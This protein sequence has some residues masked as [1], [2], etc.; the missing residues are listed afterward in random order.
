LANGKSVAYFS[1][2]HG[3]R[4]GDPLS[5]L[6]FC[7][8]EEVLSRAIAIA[9]SSGK[10]DPMIYCWGVH[11]PTHVLYA[12][13]ILIFCIATKKN[14]RYLLRIFHYYYEASGQV[15][16]PLKSKIFIGAMTANRTTMVSNLMGFTEGSIPF[17]YLGCP[18]FKG[19][20]KCV[21]FQAIVDKIKV[22]MATWK[23]SLLSIM[24][25]VQLIKSIIH[26]MLVYSFHVYQWQRRLLKTLDIW[27]KKFIQSGDLNTSK[28]CTVAWKHL[29]MPWEEGGLDLRSTSDIN[30]GLLLRLSWKCYA[31][32]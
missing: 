31:H 9:A 17:T 21:H 6:L 11:F 23:E 18:I 20:P 28:V 30:A 2:A 32:D 3:V 25:R 27:I 22:K 14:I 5:P 13:E 26:G 15:V 4:Q 8:A 24:G 7:L 19:K 1:C 10:L 16:S 12:D 29:C